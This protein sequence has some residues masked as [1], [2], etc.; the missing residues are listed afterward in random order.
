MTLSA[1]WTQEKKKQ[2]TIRKIIG[3]IK[4]EHAQQIKN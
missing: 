4:N 2:L 1:H 3:I